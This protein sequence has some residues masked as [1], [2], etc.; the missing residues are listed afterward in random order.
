[1]VIKTKGLVLCILQE[2]GIPMERADI[3]N[4]SNIDTANVGAYLKRLEK[5]GFVKKI[6]YGIY[7]ITER[8][9]SEAKALKSAYKQQTVL[10]PKTEEDFIK[11]GNE[12][13]GYIGKD[14]A[15][16]ITTELRINFSKD[17]EFRNT[18]GL[19]LTS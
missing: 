2:K 19:I 7:H 5:E 8:G 14:K 11:D 4:T 18:L 10:N 9:I 15:I 17:K 12:N 16:K 13:T 1:M 3:V 6:S